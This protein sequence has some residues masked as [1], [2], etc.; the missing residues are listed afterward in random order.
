[1]VTPLALFEAEV[2]AVFTNPVIVIASPVVAPELMFEAT[3]E[4][5]LL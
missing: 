3:V 1:M 4:P 2:V 5:A